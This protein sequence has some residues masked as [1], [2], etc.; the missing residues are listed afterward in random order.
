MQLLLKCVSMR[1]VLVQAS[2]FFELPHVIVDNAMP[3]L[4]HHTLWD[5]QSIT[6]ISYNHVISCQ[7]TS[8]QHVETKPD[9]VRP[10]VNNVFRLQLQISLPIQSFIASH[11]QRH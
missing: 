2:A 11:K 10:P 8:P 6:R 9:L 7:Q 3:E 1:R 5:Q 4:S